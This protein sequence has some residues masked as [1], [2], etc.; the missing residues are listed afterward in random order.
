MATAVRQTVEEKVV[1]FERE[2]AEFIASKSYSDRERVHE[3][4]AVPP[5]TGMHDEANMR[6]RILALSADKRN[7]TMDPPDTTKFEFDLAVMAPVARATAQYDI[8][9]EQMRFSLVPKVYANLNSPPMPNRSVVLT[10]STFGE[11]IFTAS[12]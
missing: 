2:N 9:L 10:S 6:E 5:W 4:E 7:F 1:D 8:R 11:T 3:V 12:R